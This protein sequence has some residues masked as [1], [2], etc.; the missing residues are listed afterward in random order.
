MM[1]K[2]YSC[3]NLRI[4]GR[5]SPIFGIQREG[6]PMMR[7]RHGR[8]AKRIIDMPFPRFP[9]KSVRRTACQ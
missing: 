6:L 1:R 7:K 9:S 3:R 2:A 5:P 8:R 4:I